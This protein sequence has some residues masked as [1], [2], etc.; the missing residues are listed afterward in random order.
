MIPFWIDIS[1]L[2]LFE[3]LPIVIVTLLRLSLPM[4]ALR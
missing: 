3:L 2:P 4:G 1:S